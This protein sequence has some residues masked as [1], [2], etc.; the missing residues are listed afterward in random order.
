MTRVPIRQGSR[1]LLR[2]RDAPE[3]LE[4]DEGDCEFLCPGAL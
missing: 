1:G 2:V 4:Q 3:S